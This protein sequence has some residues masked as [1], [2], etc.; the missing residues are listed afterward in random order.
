MDN[1][2]TGS[3]MRFVLPPGFGSFD[4]APE[5]VSVNNSGGGTFT[6]GFNIVEV[7]KTDIGNPVNN[8]Q[9]QFHTSDYN[10]IHS[11]SFSYKIGGGGLGLFLW[12][13]RAAGKNEFV[14]VQD[15]V[16]GGVGAGAFTS[17]YTPDYITKDFEDITKEYGINKPG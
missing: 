10:K 6:S 14:M 5:V 12:K 15:S 7:N 17:K 9:L 2:V 8:L 13:A 1:S 3:E 11:G 4:I 16:T